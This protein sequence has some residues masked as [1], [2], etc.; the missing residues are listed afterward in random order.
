MR[1]SHL[2]GRDHIE[3]YSQGVSC[4]SDALATGPEADETGPLGIIVEAGSRSEFLSL[5]AGN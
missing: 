2:T 5:A 1:Q 3:R 4:Y